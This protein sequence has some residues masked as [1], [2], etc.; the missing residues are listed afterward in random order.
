MDETQFWTADQHSV[1]QYR[2]FAVLIKRRLGDALYIRPIESDKNVE[3]GGLTWKIKR[4]S[5]FSTGD[6]ITRD[7]MQK[8]C[9][10]LV[11]EESFFALTYA[12]QFAANGP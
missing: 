7:N 2:A 9:S 5:S 4:H 6:F 1:Y 8:V 12:G 10:V 3:S 11:F